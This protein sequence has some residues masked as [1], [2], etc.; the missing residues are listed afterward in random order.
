L[1]GGLKA[2]DEIEDILRRG[3][4]ADLSRDD[5]KQGI[6]GSIVG[7]RELYSRFAHFQGGSSD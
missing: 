7:I 2:S 1:E 6:G 4:I 5:F 3:D